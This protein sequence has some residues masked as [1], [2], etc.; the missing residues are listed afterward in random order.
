M[1]LEIMNNK[2]LHFLF[3]IIF[4]PP[5]KEIHFDSNFGTKNLNYGQKIK[6]QLCI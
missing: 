1:N 4:G 2:T 6:S 5:R 3:Q